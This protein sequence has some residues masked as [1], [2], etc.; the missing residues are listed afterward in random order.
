MAHV[1]CGRANN[2]KKR[3][4]LRGN[5][6]KC[7]NVVVHVQ[8]LLVIAWDPPSAGCF[9]GREIRENYVTLN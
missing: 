5:Y 6:G 4:N 7:H 3:H 9:G 8:D 2:V 1:K